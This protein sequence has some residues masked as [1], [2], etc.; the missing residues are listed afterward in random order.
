MRMFV[1]LLL[2][3]VASC[4]AIDKVVAVEP[5][6]VVGPVEVQPL[7]AAVKRVVQGLELVGTPLDEGRKAALDKAMAGED[8]AQA[9][10][11]IQT[12]LDP[13]CLVGVSI[14]PESRVKVAQ[15]PAPLKLLQQGHRVFLVKVHN[16]GGV[17]AAVSFWLLAVLLANTGVLQ[18]VTM[19]AK[20]QKLTAKRCSSHH[21][22]SVA[23]EAL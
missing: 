19:S 17:T 12:L 4:G 7:A 16:E 10:K 2:A 21:L 23:Y 6:P 5:L 11:E 9:V 18:T 14:N 20:S 1:G 8:A 22:I 15:G 13:L 3:A